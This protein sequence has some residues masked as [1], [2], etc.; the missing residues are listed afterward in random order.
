MS[1]KSNPQVGQ[2]FSVIGRPAK[3][4]A[5][6]RYTVTYEMTKANGRTVQFRDTR[7]A[8]ANSSNIEAVAA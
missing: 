4:T 6:T 2:Q 7:A 1:S 8:F 3:V 5:V